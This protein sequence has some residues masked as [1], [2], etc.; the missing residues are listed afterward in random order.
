M[1]YV[2]NPFI[3]NLDNTGAPSNLYQNLTGNWDTAYTF[4]E[5]NSAQLLATGDYTF[6]TNAPQEILIISNKNHFLRKVNSFNTVYTNV[7]DQSTPLS[8]SGNIFEGGIFWTSST[9][10][11]SF[12][13]SK[14]HLNY[15]NLHY[16]FTQDYT[17]LAPNKSIFI[18]NPLVSA[19]RF[20]DLKLC[21][22]LILQNL[23]DIQE[24]DFNNLEYVTCI[25]GYG[26]IA[27]NS[28][29]GSGST[30]IK[31]INFPKLKFVEANI[32]IGGY[33]NISPYELSAV[34]LP[35]LE[36]IGGYI[37]I[38]NSQNM[39]TFRV[40][41]E[42]KTFE[43]PNLVQAG[44]FTLQGLPNLSSL[45]FP[46]LKKLTNSL[47]LNACSA[48]R[49]I[50]FP[51]LEYVI[52]GYIVGT[53]TNVNSLTSI[54]VPNLVYFAAGGSIT[55]TTTNNIL[56]NVELGTDTLRYVNSNFTCNQSL[57]QTSVDNL[58]KAFS[59]LDGTN[60]TVP[61]TSSLSLAG[62]NSAPSYTGG[63]TTTSAGTNFVRT[64][65][66]VVASV[67]GHG[68]TTGDIITFTGNTQAALNG[69]YTVTVNNPDEFQYTTTSTGNITGGGTVTMRRTTVATDGFRYYQTIALRGT[70]VTMNFPT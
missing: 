27:I 6:E 10:P 7:S 9:I 25:G 60:G 1:S 69:T 55:F 31:E 54:S 5:S 47:T 15:N 63:I 52:G 8:G 35:E 19:V 38:G 34:N 24:I 26:L 32:E 39:G 28:T 14:F 3:G 48:V 18:N 61:Y 2:F 56:A 64:G 12:N 45:N 59:R 20:P 41:P 46:K 11:I 30:L 67:V 37:V 23:T 13:S 53:L 29:F 62:S 16:I 51:E 50:N 44:G 49:E 43:V 68:H 36:I 4:A 70:T 57:T 58:L 66:I 22:G 21:G 33:S 65:T 42:L 40:Y 17:N